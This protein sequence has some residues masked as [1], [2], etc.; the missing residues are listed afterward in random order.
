MAIFSFGEFRE[1]TKYKVLDERVMRASAGI[2][3][4]LAMIAFSNGFLLQRFEVI[5][6]IVGFLVFNFSIGIFINPK[7]SPT[8]FLGTIFVRNQ[9]PLPIGAI[10]K[11]FA[12]SL[13][14]V[15]SSVILVL[16]ILLQG[17]I[18]YFDSV[19]LLCIVCLSLLFLETAFGIC[20]GCQLYFAARSLKI[21]P[22]PKQDERPNCMGDSCEV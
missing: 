22:E 13:G 19:C 15:L 18:F 1:G 17:D 3:L 2:M 4:L 11:K 7:F 5:P 14:L 8:V 16:S 6:Y 12:W 9:S 21:L 20:L 10:Q